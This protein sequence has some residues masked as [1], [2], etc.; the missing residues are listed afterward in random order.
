MKHLFLIFFL[1]TG[2]LSIYSQ[3]NDSIN[4]GQWKHSGSIGLNFSQTSLSNWSGGGDDAFAGNAFF[5]G[6]LEYLKGRWSWT[7]SAILEYGLTNTKTQ[8]PQ[9]TSDKMEFTTQVGY[10]TDNK[11]YYSAMADFKSQFYK[12]YNYPNK[13]N[14]IS[15]FMAPAY[16][17]VSVGIE[18]KPK[19]SFYSVYYSPVAGRFTFVEDSYLSDKGSFGVDPGKK[20]RAQLGSYLKGK[21]EKDIMDNVKLITDANFFTPYSSSFG[22]VD[23]EWNVL[24]NMKINN[25]LN[26]SINTSLKYLN[27]VKSVNEE[28]EQKGPKVQFK[29]VLGIGI[30]YNF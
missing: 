10:T 1:F 28:G 18:Y 4:I 15:K 9:K 3:N 27:D 22:N 13:T 21:L 11:W 2:S 30:G 8:G 23:I 20:F 12:G 24:V 16:S 17:N 29:E 14:Y 25:F 7:N 26:A 19:T 5:N 6:K